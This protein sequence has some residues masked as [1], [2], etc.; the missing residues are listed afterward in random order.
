MSKNEQQSEG[1]I[2]KVKKTISNDDHAQNQKK[3]RLL[4]IEKEMRQVK[5]KRSINS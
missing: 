3:K 5:R 1:F 2:D 4:L